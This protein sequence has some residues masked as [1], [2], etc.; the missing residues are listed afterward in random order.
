MITLQKLREEGHFSQGVFQQHS[1]TAVGGA[2]RVRNRSV[3]GFAGRVD[4]GEG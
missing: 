3:A 1:S 4:D 2:G